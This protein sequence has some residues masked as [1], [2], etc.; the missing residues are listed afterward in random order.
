MRNIA[1]DACVRFLMTAVFS[2]AA[3]TAAGCAKKDTRAGASESVPVSVGTAARQ[4]V[5]L[6]LRAIG[7][8]EPSTTVSLKARVNGEVT[9]VGFKDGENVKQGDLLF[10]IDPRPY[11]AALA[12][13][14]AQLERDRAM[15]Q[16]AHDTGALAPAPGSG[17]A[18]PP[19]TKGSTGTP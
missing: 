5:P 14:R 3:L 13:A 11:A 19:S 6:E 18:A 15:A 1:M 16:L 12:Q 7:H 2:A 9:K 17:T 4:D 10:Q 8:V